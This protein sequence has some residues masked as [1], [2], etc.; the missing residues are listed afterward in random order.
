MLRMDGWFYLSPLTQM[1][2]R[3]CFVLR[4]GGGSGGGGG[5][6]GGGEIKRTDHAPNMKKKTVQYQG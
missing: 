2:T 3:M 5:G 1:V 4:T 6:G